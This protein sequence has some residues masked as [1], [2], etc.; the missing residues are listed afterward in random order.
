[1]GVHI[2]PPAAFAISPRE[3][4]WVDLDQLPDIH[5]TA[6]SMPLNRKG[7]ENE[8]KSLQVRMGR[9]LTVSR[10]GQNRRLGKNEVNLVP[11][12]NRVAC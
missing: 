9:S 11:I 12:N 1:M 3:I 6:L 4:W 2:N 5:P 10:H 8:I 7:G